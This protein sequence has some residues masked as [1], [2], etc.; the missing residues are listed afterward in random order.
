MFAICVEASHKRGMGHL[1]RVF[2][3][4][5][6]LIERGIQFRVFINPN[7]TSQ[8]L[9][10]QRKLPFELIPLKSGRNDW[11]AELIRK[12][13]IKL[14]IDDRLDTNEGHASQVKNCGIPLVTFDDHGTGAKLADLNVAALTFDESDPLQGTKVLRGPRY[15]VLNREI[16]GY[17]RLRVKERSIIVSL[18]GSDTYGVT[19]MV[20]KILKEVGRTATVVV[21]PAFEHDA[22]LLAVLDERFVL[23]RCVPSLIKEFSY[24]GLA[25]TGGG[26]TPFEAAASGL[27]CVVIANEDFEIST[28]QGFAAMGAAVFAGHR[29]AIDETLLTKDLP[30]KAMSEAALRHIDLLG[31]ERVADEIEA[32]I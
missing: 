11:Q 21:G 18:G 17:R 12:Y 19:V 6:T 23:K 13:G 25:I 16:E 27:P 28:G 2:N 1:F 32:L 29:S 30:V 4:C 15:L 31:A 26:I 20:V 7:E 14:W 3:F 24:H 9:L 8:A 10:T 5:E 22:E